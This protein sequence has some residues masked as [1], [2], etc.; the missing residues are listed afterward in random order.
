[1]FGV[2]DNVLVHGSQPKKPIYKFSDARFAE[3]VSQVNNLKPFYT[4]GIFHP[5]RNNKVWMVHLMSCDMRFPTIWYVRPAKHTRSL[6]R[7]F[8]S[9]LSI[10]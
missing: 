3:V 10:L 6:I 7:A 9:R 5:I 4:N 8:T 2:E 1:M